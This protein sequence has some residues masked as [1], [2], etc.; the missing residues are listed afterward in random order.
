MKI[1]IYDIN[2]SSNLGYKERLDIYKKCGFTSVG[3]YLDDNY[4]TNN[5]KYIDI[6]KYA[7]KIRL[8]VNQ[9][10]VDYKISN[11]I[12]DEESN[13]YFDYIDNKIKECLNLNIPYLVLH[14]S[15][16][17]EA[18]LLGDKNLNKLKCMMEKHIN[19]NI[20]LCF[21]NVRDNRNLD[22]ILNSN[23]NNIRMCYDLGHAHAYSDEVELLNKYKNKIVCSHLHNN[24]G[25]DSHNLLEDGE[26]NYKSIILSFNNGVDNCLEVFPLKD[27]VLDKNEFIKF[28]QKAYEEYKKIKF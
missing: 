25:A 3:I 18:P 1:G 14:A 19:K 9:I 22:K 7:R 20:Y 24:Y 5:E 23:I 11:L 28:V 26:I 15:K 21:E 8:E 10:H 2:N 4:M 6:I 17:E 27:K 13:E 16:G 12:C